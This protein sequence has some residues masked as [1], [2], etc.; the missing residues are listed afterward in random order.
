MLCGV[1]SPSICEYLKE[2]AQQFLKDLIGDPVFHCH[3]SP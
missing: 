1:S 2:N 3:G